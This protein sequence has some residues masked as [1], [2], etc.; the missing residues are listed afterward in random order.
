M[1]YLRSI[2]LF[3]RDVK[4]N[5]EPKKATISSEQLWQLLIEDGKHDLVKILQ[6]V[7]NKDP[8]YGSIVVNQGGFSE[9]DSIHNM[10]LDWLRERNVNIINVAQNISE[11]EDSLHLKTNE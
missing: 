4:P 8:G 3:S 2:G 10:V 5:E 1:E 11:L 7:E 6:H 9:K